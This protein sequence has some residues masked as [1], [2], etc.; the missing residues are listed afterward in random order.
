MLD[1]QAAGNDRAVTRSFSDIAVLCRTHRQLEQIET[2]LA[3]DSIPCVISGRDS[4]LEN[5]TVQGLL[6]FFAALLNPCSEPSLRMAL[7]A[8]WRVPDALCQRAAVALASFGGTEIDAGSLAQELEAFELLKPWLEAANALYPR[9]RRDKPRKL[10][11]ALANLCGANG[12]PVE[13]LF[14]AAVFHNDM[15]GMLDDLL[16]GEEAD[17]R[18]ASGTGYQSGAVRLMTQRAL[19]SR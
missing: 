18:R 10:L 3:H 2:C 15:A 4:F 14:N 11:E 6:G 12:R 5:D 17:I 8:L 1:A 7:S 9:I 19:S 16:A 13:Q